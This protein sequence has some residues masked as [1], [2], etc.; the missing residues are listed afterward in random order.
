M[1]FFNSINKFLKLLIRKGLKTASKLPIIK[2]ATAPV[3]I[4]IYNSEENNT[5]P[6]KIIK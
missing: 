3:N 5:I 1:G 2:N 4:F 6:D